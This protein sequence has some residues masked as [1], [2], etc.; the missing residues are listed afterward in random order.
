MNLTTVSGFFSWG[1]IN[2]TYLFFCACYF[3]CHCNYRSQ[4]VDRGLKAQGIDRK[5][6]LHYWNRFQASMFMLWYQAR[7]RDPLPVYLAGP[8]HMGFNVVHG[9]H[10]Y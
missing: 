7:V 3:S 8:R 10:S 5:E 9:S 4:A 1:A 2:L 6:R